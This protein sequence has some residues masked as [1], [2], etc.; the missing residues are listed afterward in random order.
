MGI[1]TILD[2]NGDEGGLAVGADIRSYMEDGIAN[3]NFILYCA[4]QKG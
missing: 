4:L 2:I 1:K 3:S